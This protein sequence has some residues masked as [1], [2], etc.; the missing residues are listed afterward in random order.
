MLDL[1]RAEDLAHKMGYSSANGAFRAWCAELRISPVPGRRGLYDP[2]LVRHRLDE[3][4]GLAPSDAADCG[5]LVAARRARRAA[6]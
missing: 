6:R 3:A 5:S 1:I 2:S 4:Q